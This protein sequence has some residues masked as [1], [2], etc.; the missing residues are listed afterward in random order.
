[1]WLK[2]ELEPFVCGRSYYC[3]LSIEE[4]PSYILSKICSA[5]EE[6]TMDYEL[7][8]FV[9]EVDRDYGTCLHYRV[10]DNHNMCGWN[11][12]VEIEEIV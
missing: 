5:L 8:D 6:N 2:K 3:R 1:M 7:S 9:L 12:R 11:D 10:I 4:I